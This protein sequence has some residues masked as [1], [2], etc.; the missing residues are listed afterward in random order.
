MDHSDGHCAVVAILVNQRFGGEFMSASV[1]GVSHWFNRFRCNGTWIDV[2]LTGDQF[3]G[4]KVR[5]GVPGS[6]WNE[7]RPRSGA[8]LNSETLS[9]SG[10]LAARLHDHVR[11]CVLGGRP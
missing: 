9:R 1:D 10:L 8:E 6:L 2:D 3:G 4:D 11:S 5:M 7:T